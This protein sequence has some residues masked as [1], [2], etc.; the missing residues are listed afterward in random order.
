VAKASEQFRQ[1]DV[2]V[3]GIVA[4]FCGALAVLSA[5][6]SALLPPDILAG[7]HKT[8]IQGSSI[9]QLRADMVGLNM[10]SVRMRQENKTLLTRFALQEQ[11]GNATLQRIGALEASMPKLIEA[12]STTAEIDRSALTAAIGDG[13]TLNYAADGGTVSVRFQPLQPLITGTNQ[14]LPQALD[15]APALAVPDESA[16]GIAIGPSVS[17]DNAAATWSELSRKLGPLLFGLSPLLL[18]ETSSEQQRLVL[19]PIAQLGAATALCARLERVSIACSPMPFTG[20]PLS[21]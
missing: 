9:E 15:R 6:V 3:W 10:Q 20:A 11:A 14:P 21:F 18:D 4:L 17:S 16:F 7:L 19:G 2:T 8:R 1:S 5:N 13:E 12:L